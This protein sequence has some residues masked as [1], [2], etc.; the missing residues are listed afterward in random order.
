MTK[1][2]LIL[3]VCEGNT[4]RSP[5]AG[6]FNDRFEA[7][8]PACHIGGLST[9]GGQR[10]SEGTVEALA[11]WGIVANGR[12]SRQIRG[13]LVNDADLIVTMTLSQEARLKLTTLRRL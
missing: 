5:M 9:I 13:K 7:M 6:P 12:P 10:M 1:K 2:P 4:C 11:E 8:G 3:F